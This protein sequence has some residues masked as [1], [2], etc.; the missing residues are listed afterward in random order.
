MYC[1]FS[2]FLKDFIVNF[3]NN[4]EKTEIDVRDPIYYFFNK[5][6]GQRQTFQG[7]KFPIMTRFFYYASLS[8]VLPCSS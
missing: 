1:H 8:D 5:L 2:I 6:K 4:Y 3:K 7:K